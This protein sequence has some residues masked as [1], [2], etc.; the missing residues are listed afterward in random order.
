MYSGNRFLAIALVVKVGM[1]IG[2]NSLQ[3]E[4]IAI[5]VFGGGSSVI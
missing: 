3:V 1:T 4:V 5:P 2:Q